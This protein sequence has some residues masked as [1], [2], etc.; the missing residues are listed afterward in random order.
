MADRTTFAITTATTSVAATVEIACSRTQALQQ[1]PTLLL[2]ISSLTA[3]MNK[4]DLCHHHRQYANQQ[5]RSWHSY[6][7]ASTAHNN[8]IIG[9]LIA[10]TGILDNGTSDIT[11]TSFAIILSASPLTVLV[12][13]IT[14][15]KTVVMH[16]S[17]QQHDR[18]GNT[19][20]NGVT[21]ITLT[22]ITTRSRQYPR[23]RYRLQH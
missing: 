13:S 3:S 23:S 19:I 18:A 2:T 17:E 20:R 1:L 15:L 22:G 16:M 14:S 6:L 4:S 7:G 9:S 8:L 10:R 5:F 12:F 21:G 11:I